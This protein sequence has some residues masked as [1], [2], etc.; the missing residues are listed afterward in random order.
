MLELRR[1]F[2][3]QNGDICHYR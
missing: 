2:S 3:E 1:T